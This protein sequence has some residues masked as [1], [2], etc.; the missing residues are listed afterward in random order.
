[1]DR[2]KCFRKKKR[3]N[4]RREIVKLDGLLGG[5]VNMKQIPD[6]IFVVDTKKEHIAIKEARTLSIPD[7][8]DRGYE[9][10]PRKRGLSDSEQ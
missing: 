10:R 7:H 2:W 3:K 8:S 9:L 4:L 6:A 5:I 1:M